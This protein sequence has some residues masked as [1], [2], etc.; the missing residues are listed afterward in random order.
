MGLP[1]QLEIESARTGKPVDTLIDEALAST[2]TK[3]AA[4]KKLNI[5]AQALAQRLAKREAQ[6]QDAQVEATKQDAI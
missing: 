1:Y 5:S 3:V 4:A 6:R 2:K